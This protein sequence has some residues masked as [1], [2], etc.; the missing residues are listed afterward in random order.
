MSS[1]RTWTNPLRARF[2]KWFAYF[3]YI[4]LLRK[5]TRESSLLVAKSLLVE[6]I[7]S[8]RKSLVKIGKKIQAIRTKKE[9]HSVKKRKRSLVKA[10]GTGGASRWRADFLHRGRK[11]L[12]CI[13]LKTRFPFINFFVYVSTSL[14]TKTLAIASNRNSESCLSNRCLMSGTGVLIIM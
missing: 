8:R 10:T 9:N 7:K 4:A 14:D 2:L 13:K 6:K 5:F 1:P 12:S 11:N 3:V